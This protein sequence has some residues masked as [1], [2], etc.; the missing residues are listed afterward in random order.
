MPVDLTNKQVE[1]LMH[2]YEKNK[3]ITVSDLS[4]VFNCSKV[5]SKY[6]VDRMI[7]LGV[8]YKE[9]NFI[10]LTKIG[11]KVAA[12]YNDR[13]VDMKV[14][15]EEAFGINE[16]HAQELSEILIDNSNV[17]FQN[18]MKKISEILNKLKRKNNKIIKN[19]E[20][21]SIFGSGDYK[22]TLSIFKEKDK[23]ESSTKLSMAIRA[24]NNEGNLHIG[25]K[26]EVNI[27]PSKIIRTLDGYINKGFLKEII[28]VRNNKEIKVPSEKK[29]IKIPLSLIENWYYHGAGVLQSIVD[30]EMVANINFNKEHR[31]K[32][33]FVLTINLL[34][35]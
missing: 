5:N 18:R 10:K 1:Y 12:I 30:I 34:Q 20:M 23:F 16:E 31:N 8:F 32:A 21:E 11:N 27:Y 33:R 35:I 3:D 25:E 6:I 22:L 19:T 9:N 4:R 24:F 7:K 17:E 13:K 15:F 28:F 2:I 29:N 14:I 26:S